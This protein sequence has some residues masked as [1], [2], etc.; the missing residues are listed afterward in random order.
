MKTIDHHDAAEHLEELV[1]QAAAGEVIIIEKDGVPVAKL[2]PLE[3][4]L[5]I[6]GALA[7]SKLDVEASNALDGEI[8]RL[9]NS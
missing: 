3:A 4:S 8:A 5:P 2:T 1:A 7:G 6:I 9:F